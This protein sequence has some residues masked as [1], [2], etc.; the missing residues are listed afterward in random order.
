MVIPDWVKDAIFYQ[1]FPDRFARSAHVAKPGHLEDWKTPPTALGFKGGDLLGISEK[2]DYLQDMGI[3]ALYLN[4]IFQSSANHRY[5][6]CD[7]YK[8]DPI[9]GGNNAF[10][11]L[12]AEAHRRSLRIILDGVFNHTGRGFF[13]FNHIAENGISSPYHDWFIIHKYPIRPYHARRG[14]H[15]YQAW[16]DIPGLPKLNTTTPAVKEFLFDVACYWIKLGIDGWR[17]DVPEEIKDVKFWQG[18]RERVKSIN[19]EAY[20]VGEIWHDAEKWLQ[21]DQFDGVMNYPFARACLAFFIGK[22]ISKSAISRCPYQR[23]EP[24]NG[25]SFMTEMERL[26]RLYPKPSTD[27]QLNLLGSHDT[28]RFKTIARGDSA[29]YRLATLFQMTF[30]GAPCIYYGDEIGLEGAPDPGCRGAFPW[31]KEQWDQ[32]LR[33]YVKRCIDLRKQFKALRRDSFVPLSADEKSIAFGRQ[34]GSEKVVVILNSASKAVTVDLKVSDFLADQSKLTVIL[35]HQNPG[36]EQISVAE[37]YLRSLYVP[38]RS[39]KVMQW[40]V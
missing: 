26:L 20:L 15:G 24:M 39:G 10:K 30:P 23:I 8:V 7:Y 2:L 34:C 14:K 6:T 33:T 27:A 32:D 35:P 28:P 9:L 29:A 31:D 1:I 22:N 25:S 5:H 3:T 12:L 4:P 16:W 19:P 40:Q 13:Q 38:A 11:T 18:L 21:G 17:L 37:G 36:S